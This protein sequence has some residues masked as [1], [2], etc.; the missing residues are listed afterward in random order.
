[1]YELTTVVLQNP[2]FFFEVI[3]IINRRILQFII[4][5]QGLT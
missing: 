2:V 5:S 3:Q 4:A 1:M